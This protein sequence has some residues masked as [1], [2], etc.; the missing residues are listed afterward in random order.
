MQKKSIVWAFALLT[1]FSHVLNANNILKDDFLSIQARPIVQDIIVEA[2]QKLGVH[3]YVISSNEKLEQN[4]NLFEYVKAYESNLSKPYAVL[5][6]VPR[7]MR[8]GL[9]PSSSDIASLYNA[10]DV[11]AALIDVVAS[12]DKN[13][14][15]DKYNIGIV[16]GVSELAEQIAKSKGVVLTKV[17]PNDTK[18]V[19]N[20]FR[21]IVY[22]GTAFVIWIFMFRP[23]LRRFKND[24]NP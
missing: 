18:E 21:Y 9:I 1:L 4:V 10:N 20:V 11:K 19:I 14:L 22:I 5:V 13:K 16:Q 12:A 24:N 15:E 23:L 3:I 6:F 8:V 2:K 7:S 17:I